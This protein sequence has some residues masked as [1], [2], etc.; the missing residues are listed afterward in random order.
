MV[1]SRERH[2]AYVYQRAVE[3]LPRNINM[4]LRMDTVFQTGIDILNMDT[5]EDEGSVY[6]TW[7][8][9]ALVDAQDRERKQR[10]SRRRRRRT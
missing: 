7:V 10:G 3:E 4:N 1:G 5:Q 2:T 6:A 9:T 8:S